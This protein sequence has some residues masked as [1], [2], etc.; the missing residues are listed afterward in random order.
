MANFNGTILTNLGKK[1]IAQSL[2]G[3]QFEITKVVLGDGIWDNI[4][5]EELTSLI[6]PKLTL[7]IVDKEEAGDTVR[8]R[9]LLTNEGI[10]EGFFIRELGVIAEDKTTGEEILYAVAYASP[11]DYLPAGD[12][13]TK[14]ETGFDVILV[15][16]NSP[17]ITVRIS[18]TIMVA[19]KEDIQQ[20]NTSADAHPD[21]RNS[22]NSH[23]EDLSAHDI[24][25]QISSA[26]TSHNQDTNAHQDIRQIILDFQNQFGGNLTENGY[27]RLSNGL[28]LQW[29]RIDW[30]NTSSDTA[31]KVYADIVFPIAFPNNCFSITA[32]NAY[33]DD[34]D[35][36]TEHTLAVSIIDNTRAQIRLERL[37]GSTDGNEMGHTFWIAIG[38]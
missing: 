35:E 7:P 2:T 29:G 21:I 14:V 24:P 13:P 6:S 32:T 30:K 1:A 15:T 19:T 16:A 12:G 10:T 17:N 8:I 5:P 26:I 9:V 37:Y 20:H 27:Y 22:L 25:N 11:A 3:K 33:P 34:G 4:N 18:D 31:S 36:S 38:Y 28:I 23:I